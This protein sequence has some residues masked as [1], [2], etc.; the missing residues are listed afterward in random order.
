MTPTLHSVAILLSLPSLAAL[1]VT[2]RHVTVAPVQTRCGRI[3]C[4]WGPEP[5]WESL[6]VE[7]IEDAASG[8]KAI[9]IAPPES[10][11]AEFKKGGQYVQ[12]REP[13]AEKAGFFAI[14]S[15][16]GK[17]G[18]FEF[19]I[20]E[21]PPSDW[22]PGTGWLTDSSAGL[23]LEMS[24]VMGGGFLKA[25]E[26]LEGADSVLLF[27]AGSGISPLRSVIES[28]VLKGKDV[29][30]YYGA[31]TPA[32]MAYQDKFGEWEALGVSVTP[33]ISKPDGTDWSGATGY[34]QDVC[35]AAGV[36]NPGSTAILLCG[37]KGMA[38]GIKELASKVGIPEDKVYNNF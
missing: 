29:S 30:L 37:M 20:K 38:E 8:L 32:Q 22:S 31:Q 19:L 9:T 24:Q 26:A 18:S 25:D 14:A 28:Q 34:V 27:A 35:E 21:Q 23:K 12:I 1:A 10:V 33:V 5:V 16:P 6:T 36:A 2:P 13:G 7:S 3:L 17:E 11:A 15:A 4:G